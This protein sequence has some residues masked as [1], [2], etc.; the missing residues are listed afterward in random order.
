MTDRELLRLHLEAVWTISLPALDGA[1][2]ELPASRALPPWSLYQ[3]QFSG[4]GDAV[5]P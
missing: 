4:Y 3:A 1:S 2:V 5:A